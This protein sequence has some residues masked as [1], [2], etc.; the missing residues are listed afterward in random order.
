MMA[1]LTPIREKAL[2]LRE[3]PDYVIEGLRKGATECKR[4]AQETMDEVQRTLGL[5]R[6]PAPQ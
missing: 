5:L 6:L 3:H 2:S 1:E 4:M